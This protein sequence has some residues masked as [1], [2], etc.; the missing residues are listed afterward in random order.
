MNTHKVG[1][2]RVSSLDQNPDRQLENLKL[3]RVFID[4]ASGKD[5]VRPQ[6]TEM[7]AYV[8][9][10]DTIVVHS[11]DRLARNL[12]DLRTMVH[13]LTRR[14]VR[15][16]FVKEA[17]TFTG[18]DSPMSHLL[19]SVMGA[20]AEFERELI[21]ERQREGIALAKKRGAYKGRRKALNKVQ[22]EEL[23]RRID[24]GESKADLLQEFGITR[25]TLYRYLGGN[26]AGA[27]VGNV[28][29]TIYR[30]NL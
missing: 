3:D 28:M 25:Q 6:L 27:E 2:V 18:D 14:G 24:A 19:L 26:R 4:K 21:R 7:L 10:G 1:Y 8:R 29:R 22:I 30:S 16:E 13:D 23:S 9:E 20:V 11:M 5:T 12:L 15:V 17:L